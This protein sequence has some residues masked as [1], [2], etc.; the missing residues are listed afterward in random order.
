MGLSAAW[1][2][3]EAFPSDPLGCQVA[4]CKHL[5]KIT[6]FYWEC[7]YWCFL[8]TGSAL[9]KPK[10]PRAGLWTPAPPRAPTAHHGAHPKERNPK[11]SRIIPSSAFHGM[12]RLLWI[13]LLSLPD[14][15]NKTFQPRHMEYWLCFHSTVLKPELIAVLITFATR[16]PH[17]SHHKFFIKWGEILFSA[18]NK[19]CV[20]KNC[21]FVMRQ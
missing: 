16:I 10:I 2:S 3:L 4:S 17:E 14:K 8:T 5:L 15:C 12:N 1:G 11:I 7:S 20:G 9:E 13:H 18:E 19:V 21:S 6:C